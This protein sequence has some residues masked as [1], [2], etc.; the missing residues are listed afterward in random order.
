M[1]AG[2]PVICTPTI[3][4]QLVMTHGINGYFAYTHEDWKNYI[5]KLATN[6]NHR[7]QIG[8]AARNSVTRTYSI[9]AMTEH[10]IQL[11]NEIQFLD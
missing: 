1:A 3:A 2:I 11:F 10:Y 8:K 4:D 9:S 6:A 7:Q 5:I